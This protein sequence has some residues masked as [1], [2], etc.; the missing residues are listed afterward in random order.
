MKS[1]ETTRKCIWTT[2]GIFGVSW[3]LRSGMT[4]I[5]VIHKRPSA[6]DGRKGRTV[7]DEPP[8][9]R[10]FRDRE[11]GHSHIRNPIRSRAFSGTG[12]YVRIRY[13]GVDY[14]SHDKSSRPDHTQSSV[15]VY[16]SH[17]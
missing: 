9:C 13:A 14:P 8:H 15:L 2:A 10:S 6:K 17:D 3:F 5:S 11:S 1:C 12:T 4:S 16:C 7:T